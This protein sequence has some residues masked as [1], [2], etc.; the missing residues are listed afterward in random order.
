MGMGM[1]R[2]AQPLPALYS[3]TWYK[4]VF[5]LEEDKVFLVPLLLE[6]YIERYQ[7]YEVVGGT[8]RYWGL[9]CHRVIYNLSASSAEAILQHGEDC[10]IQCRAGKQE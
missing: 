8:A 2:P 6:V 10:S 1:A 5:L 3:P 9:R 4:E 7:T